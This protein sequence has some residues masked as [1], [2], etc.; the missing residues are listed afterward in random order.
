[1]LPEYCWIQAA[2]THLQPVL[3][4]CLLMEDGTLKQLQSGKPHLGLSCAQLDRADHLTKKMLSPDDEG[5]GH[6]EFKDEILISHYCHSEQ[7]I[8]KDS[9]TR[10]KGY[11][12][13]ERRSSKEAVENVGTRSEPLIIVVMKCSPDSANSHVIQAAAKCN[14]SL[15]LGKSNKSSKSLWQN[16]KTKCILSNDVKNLITSWETLLILSS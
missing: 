5:Q 13:S 3:L 1:M 14:C 7:S 4:H 16:F 2:V 11:C 8:Q 6:R 10:R 12:T 15:E 9:V